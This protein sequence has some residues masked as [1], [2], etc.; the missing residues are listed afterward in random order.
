MAQIN[1]THSGEPRPVS[2]NLKTFGSF[3]LGARPTLSQGLAGGP[4]LGTPSQMLRFGAGDEALGLGIGEAETEEKEDAAGAGGSAVVKKAGPV[5]G[6]P[7]GVG[8]SGRRTIQELVAELDPRVT[9]DTEMESVSFN[10][11]DS[12]AEIGQT[13]TRCLVFTRSSRR[14]HR[15]GDA[16]CM[17]DCEASWV[18]SGRASRYTASPW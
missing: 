17:S 5:S 9:V 14:V 3:R 4:I 6:E 12:R 1:V 16:F 18:G 10:F 13:N 15:F 8:M 2:K 11:V 7:V